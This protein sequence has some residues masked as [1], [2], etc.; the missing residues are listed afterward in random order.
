LKEYNSNAFGGTF[1]FFP[2][3]KAKLKCKR[4]TKPT[5]HDRPN[6]QTDNQ[7]MNKKG[8]PLT[9]YWRNGGFIAKFNG[10]SSIEFLCKTEH[11]YFDFRHYANTRNK[12][13][14]VI[15]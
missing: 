12:T 6:E 4:A 15:L 11:L 7:H 3:H 13:L 8:E 1:A 14:A 10:I 9:R 5:H 2:T